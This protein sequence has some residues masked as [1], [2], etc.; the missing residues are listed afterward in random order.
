[1][2]NIQRD[3]SP[4]NNESN[5]MMSSNLLTIPYAVRPPQI[6]HNPYTPS[7][8]KHKSWHIPVYPQTSALQKTLTK[9]AFK[10]L[11]FANMEQNFL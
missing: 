2:R 3:S 11:T 10:C 8:T 9:F 7:G 1:M 4:K 5:E 6:L